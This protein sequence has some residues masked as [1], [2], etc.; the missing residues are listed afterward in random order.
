[1]IKPQLITK[2]TIL[3]Q[4]YKEY[5]LDNKCNFLE[6]ERNLR[7]GSNFFLTQDEDT[8][9]SLNQILLLSIMDISVLLYGPSGTGKELLAKM[10]H[11]GRE[12]PLINVNCGAIPLELFEAEF[13]GAKKGSYTGCFQNRIGYFQRANEGTLFL[14]EIGELPLPMQSKLLR[15][16]ESQTATAIGGDEY[17]FTTRIVSATNKDLWQLVLDGKFRED[18]F[19]R[20]QKATIEIKPLTTRPIDCEYLYCLYYKRIWGNKPEDKAQDKFKDYFFS[21][22]DSCS[23]V[24][25]TKGNCRAIINYCIK[26][27][28]DDV[29]NML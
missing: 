3:Q 28:L 11:N 7:K 29:V 16:L 1:M 24:Q 25:L 15:A 9:R 21:V 12:R 20:L 23:Y 22:E 27:A 19:F 26:E 2:D 6:I 5:N 14:D 4:F 13:F 8:I 17:S 18:L 10:L